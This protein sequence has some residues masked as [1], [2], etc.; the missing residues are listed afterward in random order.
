MWAL[1]LTLIINCNQ[2]THNLEVARA[3]SVSDVY[4]AEQSKVIES[5][6]GLQ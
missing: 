2:I 5:V 6:C 3:Y 4:N 1:F